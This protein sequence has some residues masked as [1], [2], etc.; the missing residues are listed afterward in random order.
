MD[1]AYDARAM[2]MK[3]NRVA[4]ERFAPT[5]ERAFNYKT[6]LLFCRVPV[7]SIYIY[8]YVCMYMYIYI[9]IVL[10]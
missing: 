8:I 5:V 3:A 4:H 1:V 6:Y 9:Y 2:Q 7:D 10:Y